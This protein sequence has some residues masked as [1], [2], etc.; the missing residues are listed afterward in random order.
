V[1]HL[2]GQEVLLEVTVGLGPGA[3]TVWTCDLT[4]GYIAINAAYRS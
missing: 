1:A 3:A 2:R 4:Q